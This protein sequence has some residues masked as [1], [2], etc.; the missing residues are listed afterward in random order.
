MDLGQT[1]DLETIAVTLDLRALGARYPHLLVLS[2][3]SL[4]I[5]PVCPE[6][7]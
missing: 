4:I 6:F 2:S 3:V 7:M 1:E 5:S